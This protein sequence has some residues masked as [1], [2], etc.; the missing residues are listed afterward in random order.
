MRIFLIT[1]LAGLLFCPEASLARGGKD[2]RIFKSFVREVKVGRRFFASGP[3]GKQDLEGCIFTQETHFRKCKHVFSVDTATLKYARRNSKSF[4]ISGDPLSGFSLQVSDRRLQEIRK[5]APR[6]AYIA[7]LQQRAKVLKI[8]R[9]L[10]THK[11]PGEDA[12]LQEKQPENATQVLMEEQ[13]KYVKLLQAQLSKEKDL[14]I[15]EW[16]SKEIKTYQGI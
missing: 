13:Q 9:D 4:V 1:L 14:S 15:E 10:G 11:G 16:I 3:K 2:T 12:H 5:A 6:S 7:V 8:V